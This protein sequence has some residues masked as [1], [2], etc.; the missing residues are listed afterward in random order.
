MKVIQVTMYEA[1]DGSRHE[2]A[3]ACTKHEGIGALVEFF[4]GMVWDVCLDDGDI[5]IVVSALAK[6]ADGIVKLLDPFTTKEESSSPSWMF[7]QEGF[8]LGMPLIP[9]IACRPNVGEFVFVMGN[10]GYNTLGGRWCG[11]ACLEPDDQQRDLEWQDVS[12]TRLSERG[13]VVEA[14][15]YIKK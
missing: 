5:S 6:H 14:W 10:S 4:K 7:A 12:G 11:F 2:S 8:P 9:T 1:N 3:E 15:A 13:I